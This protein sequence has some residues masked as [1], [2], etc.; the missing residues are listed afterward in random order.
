M[1][2]KIKVLVI[3]D[4][5]LVRKVMRD[6]INS[7][8]DMEVMG[9]AAD[10]YIAVEKMK[11]QKP[12]VITLDVEMP[13]MDGL[14]FLK[15]LMTQ[16]PVPVIIVSSLSR[17]GGEVAVRAL[18]LGAV[19]I[20]LKEDIRLVSKDDVRL[21]QLVEMIRTAGKAKVRKHTKAL[22]PVSE[23]LAVR[24]SEKIIVLGAST[25][26]TVAIQEI[27]S[28]LPA[29]SP[30]MVIVQHMPKDF[31]MYFANRLNEMSAMSVKEAEEGD[32]VLPG[33]VLIAPG[34]RHVQLMRYGA[35]IMIRTWDGPLVNRHKPSID[36]LFESAAQ[37]V[38]RNGIGV[39]LTGMGKDGAN[40]L[41]SMKKSGALTIAQDEASCIV[42]GMPKE[43]I[44]LNAADKVLPLSEIPYEL[45]N[46][47]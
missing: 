40:G 6:C 21:Q 39:L 17:T 10:P 3:D 1:S 5:A 30:G 47:S 25:G 44:K 46:A 36:V 13:R 42:F 26:G 4:A 11:I 41:L 37:Q 8:K 34:D 14:T 38:G 33:K 16:H 7:Q 12:D 19:D 9:M 32:R 20:F 22:L 27:V 43:A 24:T 2:D 28:A 23:L 15:Q 18:E 35:T 29:N 31:T 45:L